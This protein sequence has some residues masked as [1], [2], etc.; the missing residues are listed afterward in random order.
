MPCSPVLKCFACHLGLFGLLCAVV[1][2]QSCISIITEQM[3]G[4]TQDVS[5]FTINPFS[6]AFYM[7]AHKQIGII[8]P[9]KSSKD[10]VHEFSHEKP[11]RCVVFNKRFGQVITACD[12]GIVKMFAL[13]NGALVVEFR[14]TRHQQSPISSMVLDDSGTRYKSPPTMSAD[15]F[16]CF[17]VG[18]KSSQR[19]NLFLIRRRLC[20]LPRSQTLHLRRRIARRVVWPCPS[21]TTSACSATT[22]G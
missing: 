20:W 13:V 3:H 6:G 7:F 19:S 22:A 21:F 12:D 10:G 15:A 18:V 11:V 5:S 16:S 1:Q 17:L 14:I 8:Q 2:A 9:T 4:V